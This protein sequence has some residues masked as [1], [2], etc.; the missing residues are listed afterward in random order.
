MIG[1][2][3]RCGALS[4]LGG[5]LML[6]VG[7][8]ASPSLAKLG[9]PAIVLGLALPFL[10]GW[11]RFPWARLVPGVLAVASV[12]WSNW[13]LADPRSWQVAGFAG[14]RIAFF[15]LPGLVFAAFIDPAELGDHLGQRLH[16]P[17]RPVLAAVAAL[18]RWQRLGS[19]W[20]E[21]A[22][23]R[24]LRGLGAT[25][26]PFALRDVASRMTALLTSALR[27]A[28]DTAVAM[29]ARGYS[30]PVRDR[31]PRTWAYPAPWHG[32][33]LALLAICGV[34]AAAAL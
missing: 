5:S 34:A 31:T 13:L 30:R 15:V 14:L 8:L 9:P 10:A 26:S 25:R 27:D 22:Q 23:I 28:T 12:T 33:D 7:A 29:E 16:L 3:P 1:L 18:Q 24:R 4:L 17:A 6:M 2:L 20:E 19:D 21:L 32:T 11:R